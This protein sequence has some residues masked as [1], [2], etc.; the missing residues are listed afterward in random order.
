MPAFAFIVLKYVS[1]IKYIKKFSLIQNTYLEKGGILQEP[2]QVIVIFLNT[3]P[4][5]DKWEC[6][7][8][9][10]VKTVMWNQKSYQ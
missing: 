10:Y 4:E 6:L 2:Y 9:F 7:I 3:I 1:W 8:S 5:L